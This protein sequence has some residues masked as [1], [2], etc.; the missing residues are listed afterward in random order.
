MWG[1]CALLNLS[2]VPGFSYL[3]ADF[4]NSGDFGSGNLLK[5]VYT[6]LRH[7]VLLF[8]SKVLSMLLLRRILPVIHYW[9]FSDLGI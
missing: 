8:M 6:E 9:G 2:L 3:H 4:S 1:I 7:S 5:K